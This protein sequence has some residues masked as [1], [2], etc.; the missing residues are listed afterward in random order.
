MQKRFYYRTSGKGGTKMRTFNS[1]MMEYLIRRNIKNSENPEKN[2]AY[3]RENMEKAIAKSKDTYASARVRLKSGCLNV[4]IP[5]FDNEFY[6]LLKKYTIMCDYGRGLE[7]DTDNNHHRIYFGSREEKQFFADMSLFEINA[8]GSRYG[9]VRPYPIYLEKE[10]YETILG[11]ADLLNKLPLSDLR[12]VVTPAAKSKPAQIRK[13]MKTYS[14]GDKT[15]K[16]DIIH[17][18]EW[19][20]TNEY[21]T[22]YMKIICAELGIEIPVYDKWYKNMPVVKAILERY[23]HFGGNIVPW[24]IYAVDKSLLS[25]R[26]NSEYWDYHGFDDDFQRNDFRRNVKIALD[27]LNK[28][29]LDD[30]FFMEK[31]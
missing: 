21:S 25:H 6:E 22:R 14:D 3:T 18:L 5:E 20:M 23:E 28:R 13:I 11:R 17:W 31:L 19:E 7:L 24:A 1:L 30:S 29:V 8:S 12:F 16:N 9:T 26:P 27:I 2:P 4:E 10:Q 15:V